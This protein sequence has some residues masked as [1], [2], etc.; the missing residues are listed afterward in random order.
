MSKSIN[1]FKP[2]IVYHFASQ[3]IVLDAIKDPLDNFE[4]NTMGLVNVLESC[5]NCKSIQSIIIA[6]SDKCYVNDDKKINFTENDKLG[7]KEPYAA[8]KACQK[9]YQKHIMKLILKKKNRL[10]NR[11]GR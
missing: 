10:S 1:E 6:T 5:K 2:D 4:I 9:L 7:G 8:S 11:K 3:A